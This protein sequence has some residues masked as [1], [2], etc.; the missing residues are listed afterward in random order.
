MG[1]IF[2]LVVD[3]SAK[4]WTKVTFKVFLSPYFEKNSAK[5]SSDLNLN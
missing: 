4:F 5:K 3:F 1:E 2:R